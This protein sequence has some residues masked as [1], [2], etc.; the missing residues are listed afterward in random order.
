MRNHV[1]CLR[2]SIELEMSVS[3]PENAGVLMLMHAKLPSSLLI[4]MPAGCTRQQPLSMPVRRRCTMN[5][6]IGLLTLF[7]FIRVILC[8]I[9]GLVKGGGL[10]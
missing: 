9:P 4:A 7:P 5:T 10:Q 2:G 8:F 6:L 1:F 3:L